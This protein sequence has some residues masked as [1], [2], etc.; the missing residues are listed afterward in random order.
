MFVLSVSHSITPP[1]KKK[2]KQ[3][4]NKKKKTKN[5]TKQKNNK[6]KKT[7][8]KTKKQQKTC[9]EINWF[10]IATCRCI[11]FIKDNFFSLSYWAGILKT[12]SE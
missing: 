2:K 6:K 3:K 5:K 9:S 1:K 11:D 10:D 7:K 4:K 12:L 8:K